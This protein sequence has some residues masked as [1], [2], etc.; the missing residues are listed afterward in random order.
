M[1]VPLKTIWK[2]Q[3][4]QNPAEM[5]MPTWWTAIWAILTANML[6]MWFNVLVLTFKVLHG[7]GLSYLRYC[8]STMVLHCHYVLIK[9]VHSRSL[10]LKGV[11]YGIGAQEGCLLCHSIHPLEWEFPPQKKICTAPTL[12]VFCKNLKTWLFSQAWDGWGS[13]LEVSLFIVI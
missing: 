5:G 13:L 11:L 4:I 6:W 3:L 8:L 9:M 12:L 10:Q 1:D 7:I 2:I